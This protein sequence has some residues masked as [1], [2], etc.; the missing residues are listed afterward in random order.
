M[1]FPGDINALVSVNSSDSLATA[2]HAARHNEVKTALE[3]VRNVLGGTAV[4]SG[5]VAPVLAAGAA[6]T[7]SLSFTGDANTG[8]WSPAADA[9][10]ASTGGS[11]RLRID[12]SGNVGIGTSTPDYP[13]SVQ[14][15]G[16]ANLSLKNSSGV[17]KAY[18]GTAGVFGTG[19]TDDLRIRSESTNIL[20]G[21]SGTE[22]MRITSAGLITG[23]GTSL[24]AWTSYTPT[25]TASTTNPTLG[26]G[27]TAS[28]SYMQIGKVCIFRVR[29]VFG[30]SGV[31]AGSGTYLI[32][33]PVAGVTLQFPRPLVNVLIRDV[34]TGDMWFGLGL[35]N[36]TTDV[37]LRVQ[38]N[39][40]G[41]AWVTD[42]APYAW[43]ASDEILAF[44]TYE[45]A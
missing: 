9:I 37:S 4:T 20:F 30:T 38:T 25:L 15:S 6:G 29:I 33:L 18:I 5:A 22:R 41:T 3:G 23:T 34:S 31:A 36:S 11:E 40:S 24:G 16:D 35:Y 39:S 14:S 13:L 8:L 17:S 42:S 45:I 44:G 32:S 2:G 19:S 7:P 10:A 43:A 12:S 21:F 28:G 27:S 1:A 26:T